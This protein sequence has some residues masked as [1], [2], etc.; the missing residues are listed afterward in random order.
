MAVLGQATLWVNGEQVLAVDADRLTERSVSLDLAAGRSYDVRI[1]YVADAPNQCCPGRNNI[2]PAIRFSWSPPNA[3]ASPQI[4]EAVRAARGSDVAVVVAN[5]YLGE[6]LDRGHLNLPQNQDR[7]IDAVARANPNTIVVLTTGAPVELPWLNRVAGV[8]ESWY[9]GQ[10]QGRAV[11]ALLF[12]DEAFAGKLPVTWP[13]SQDQVTEG[14]GIENPVYD[15]NNPGITVPHDEGVFLGYR[16][17]DQ[18]RIDPL[19]PFGY[20]LTSE[21]FRY[22]NI[23]I[24]NPRAGDNGRAGQVRVRVQNTGATTAT[25]VVQVYHGQLPTDRAETPP[26][27]LLGWARVTLEPRQSRWVDVPVRLDTPEHQLAYW[28]ADRDAWVTPE[29]RTAIY[30]GSSSRDVRLTGNITV[31]APRGAGS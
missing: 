25:E 7:L 4:Q 24:T 3:Q 22:S 13:R 5:D 9:P 10:E 8:F 31:L 11:A 23:T 19:F 14:L 27:Q 29:G 21:R 20:G 18:R 26:R 1:D 2:G 15:L 30:A 28:D 16:G 6:A 17:F 12:G